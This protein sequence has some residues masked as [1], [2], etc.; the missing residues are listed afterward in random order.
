MCVHPVFIGDGA[1]PPVLAT[2]AAETGGARFQALPDA[3]RPGVL[4]LVDFGRDASARLR[5]AERRRR[6]ARAHRS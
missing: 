2:L 1:Y 6:N 3:R 4:T 5:V